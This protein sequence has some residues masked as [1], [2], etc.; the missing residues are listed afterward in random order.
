MSWRNQARCSTAYARPGDWEMFP[1]DRLEKLRPQCAEYKAEVQRIRQAYCWRCPVR[2][3]CLRDGMD[4]EGGIW[5]G[6][7]PQE[8]RR[9]MQL[10]CRC[11]AALDPKDIVKLR[12][13]TC[14]DCARI[15]ARSPVRS[16][17]S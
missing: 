14:P 5:G 6:L 8:R 12:V 10:D 1:E 11:G 9:V 16:V 3:Q 4:E 13:T 17:A 15:G 2:A 7:T